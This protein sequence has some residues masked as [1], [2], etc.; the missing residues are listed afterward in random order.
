MS[1]R[2]LLRLLCQ[3]GSC[4][5]W[6]LA[7]TSGTCLDGEASRVSCAASDMLNR[8]THLEC[9]WRVSIESVRGVA[10]S[11]RRRVTRLECQAA[12]R[13]CVSLA[14]VCVCARS[15]PAPR[16]LSLLANPRLCPSNDFMS[17]ICSCLFLSFY[18]SIHLCVC[19]TWTSN[20]LELLLKYSE[21][22]FSEGWAGE[23]EDV[24]VCACA[25]VS[26]FV[27]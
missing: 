4:R 10:R 14:R 5:C 3:D 7:G 9:G 25:R 19:L 12:P 17:A 11:E 13:V 8:A 24:C 23:D 15:I 2:I 1:R 27:L 6:H 20:H 18:S 16:S 22:C 21:R 26:V